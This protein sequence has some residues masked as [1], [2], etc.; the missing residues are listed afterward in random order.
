MDLEK[1]HKEE[2]TQHVRE[3][4]LTL[5]GVGT[6]GSRLYFI[7][8]N[9]KKVRGIS[10]RCMGKA[11]NKRIVHKEWKNEEKV[12]KKEIEQ[13]AKQNMATWQELRNNI[14]SI[15]KEKPKV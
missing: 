12:N 8:F 14:C 1:L 3:I 4:L 15:G 2:N 10:Y 13:L 7:I 6:K 9:L 11:S 5:P